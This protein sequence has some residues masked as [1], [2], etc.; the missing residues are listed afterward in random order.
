[1]THAVELTPAELD[2]LEE[3]LEREARQLPVEIHHTVTAK[4]RDRLRRRSELVEAVLGRIRCSM[5]QELC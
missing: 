3:L 5:A 2:L 4:Y 1:M